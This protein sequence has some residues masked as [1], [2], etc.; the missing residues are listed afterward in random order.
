MAFFYAF[1]IVKGRFVKIVLPL[2]NYAKMTPHFPL[3]QNLKFVNQNLKFLSLFFFVPLYSENN[4]KHIII[5]DYMN[6]HWYTIKFFENLASWQTFRDDRLLSTSEVNRLLN[7]VLSS[8]NQSRIVKPLRFPDRFLVSLLIR[9]F[10]FSDS[11]KG[12]ITEVKFN[13]RLDVVVTFSNS[14]L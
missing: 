4:N 7:T 8:L 12:H 14:I 5:M 2:S 9:Q 10:N 6:T 11:L 3:E 1:G 13:N